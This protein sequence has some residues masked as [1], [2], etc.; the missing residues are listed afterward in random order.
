MAE[1]KPL[2][3]QHTE[4]EKEELEN[5][6][7]RRAPAPPQR[8]STS[9]KRR[10]SRPAVRELGARVLMRTVS[11]TGPRQYPRNWRKLSLDWPCTADIVGSQCTAYRQRDG[12]H[13][14][15]ETTV[16]AANDA[17]RVRCTRRSRSRDRSVPPARCWCSAHRERSPCRSRT[18]PS[19]HRRCRFA[20]VRSA[21][22]GASP[23]LRIRESGP[24]I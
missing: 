10:T 14:Q 1:A 11:V 23:R 16:T 21:C 18:G 7:R 6:A 9:R 19:A 2:T 4:Y 13:G 20:P 24:E 22:L 3:A 15:R 5:T 17:L 12:L 8:L